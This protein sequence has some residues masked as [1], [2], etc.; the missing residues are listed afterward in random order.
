MIHSHLWRVG[1]FAGCLC[2]FQSLQANDDTATPSTP[3]PNYLGASLGSTSSEFCTGLNNCGETGNTWKAYSGVRMG[4]KIFVE[5]GYVKFG[6]QKGNDGSAEVSSKAKG[7]ST[8]G[9]VTYSL[10]EQIELFGKAGM[11]WWKNEKKLANTTTKAEGSDL[12]LGVGA[13][14]NLGD[15]MG[16]RAEWERYQM[17]SDDSA[18]QALDLLSVGVTFSSL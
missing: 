12:L 9:V 7:Y 3:A 6:E 5:G 17:S 4:E 8:A 10:N 13:N 14:Y 2:F 11:W 15:N 16:V 1:V 18:K